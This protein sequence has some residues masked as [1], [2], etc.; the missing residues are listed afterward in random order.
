MWSLGK[1][2]HVAIAVP[3][4]E[5]AVALYKNVLNA[6]SVSEKLVGNSTMI[7]FLYFNWLNDYTSFVCHIL[8]PQPDHG[9]YTVFIELGNTKIEVCVHFLVHFEHF[10]YIQ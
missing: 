4:M 9:V 7:V 3:D 6:T 10:I 1:L 5:K 8:K 2:N